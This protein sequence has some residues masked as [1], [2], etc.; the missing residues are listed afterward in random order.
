MFVKCQDDCIQAEI[1]TPRLD[2]R[3]H[4]TLQ[5]IC[6][7]SDCKW[8]LLHWQQSTPLHIYMTGW[9]WTGHTCT[10]LPL[11]SPPGMTFCQP[12]FEV[13]LERPSKYCPDIKSVVCCVSCPVFPLPSTMQT[14]L[15]SEW[16]NLLCTNTNDHLITNEPLTE[17]EPLLQSLS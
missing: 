8:G 17:A 11:G 1:A 16:H 13:L 10:V 15:G 5:C 14:C 9:G 7:R 3:R 6:Y 4:G 12:A 2:F